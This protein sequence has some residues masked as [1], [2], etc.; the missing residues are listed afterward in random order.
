MKW[1][2]RD[3]NA[4]AECLSIIVVFDD[5]TLNYVIFRMLDVKWGPHFVDGIACSYNTKLARSNS[6]LHQPG[7]EAVDAFTYLE[8]R[9][10]LAIAPG[11]PDCTS[12]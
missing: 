10:Q 6:G 3:L 11:F 1:I 12:Y 2:P 9:E 4:E 5:N 7:T 8:T